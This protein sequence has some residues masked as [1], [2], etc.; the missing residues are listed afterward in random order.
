MERLIEIFKV[1]GYSLRTVAYIT[2]VTN[3]HIVA[4]TSEVR[5]SL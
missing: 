2:I 4:D 3:Q 1:I 5:I